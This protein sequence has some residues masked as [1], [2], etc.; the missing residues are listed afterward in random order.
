MMEERIYRGRYKEVGIYVK[1]GL[2]N[3]G[4]LGL[5]RFKMLSRTAKHTSAVVKVKARKSYDYLVICQ[6]TE[7]LDTPS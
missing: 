3:D 6:L 1:Y 4:G 5:L 7:P 2:L